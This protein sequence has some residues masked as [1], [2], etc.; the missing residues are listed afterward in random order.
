M[1]HIRLLLQGLNNYLP[2][3]PNIGADL[4]SELYWR[5]A[6]CGIKSWMSKKTP[7]VA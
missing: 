1:R 6:V 3:Y 4:N 5:V 2:T 7:C